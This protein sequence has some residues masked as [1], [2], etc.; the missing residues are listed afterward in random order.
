MTSKVPLAGVIGQPVGHSKSPCLHGWWLARYGLRGH[1]V[2]LEIA[3][4]DL[5]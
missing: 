4:A 3:E 2:P 5:A 1:Y